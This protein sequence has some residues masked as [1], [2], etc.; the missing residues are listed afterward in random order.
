MRIIAL[1]LAALLISVSLC[2]ADNTH[3]KKAY[4]LYYQ[5]KTQAA[6]KLMKDYV[7]EKPDPKALYFLGYAYYEQKDMKTALKY[8]EEAYLIDPDI[9]PMS[10]KKQ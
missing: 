8:F 6:I 10:W 3:V 7:D 4:T 2:I 1:T 5:G 9:S